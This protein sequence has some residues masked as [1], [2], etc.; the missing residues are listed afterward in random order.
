[1]GFLSHLYQAIAIF[2]SVIINSVASPFL[3]F[4][5]YIFAGGSRS[6]EATV[7]NNNLS[8]NHRATMN[9]FISIFAGLASAVMLYACG[10]AA[11]KFGFAAVFYA[12]CAMQIFMALYW[13]FA[14]KK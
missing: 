8:D 1:M 11:D 12:L 10:V 2:V 6:A 5:S 7:V 9:S 3:F 14:L 13:K 4:A